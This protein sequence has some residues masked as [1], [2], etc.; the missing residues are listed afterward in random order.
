MRNDDTL[1]QEPGWLPGWSLFRDWGIL[2]EDDTLTRIKKRMLTRFTLYM[3]PLAL[4]HGGYLAIHQYYP[5]AIVIACYLCASAVNL[6][7][8][9]NQKN[10]GQF[11][12][13]QI[14]LI[15]LC[16]WLLTIL[17]GGF[18][19]SGG[20]AIW[21]ML[22]PMLTLLMHNDKA[23]ASWFWSVIAG[24]LSLIPLLGF[25]PHDTG[26][27][28][29]E[30]RVFFII[31]LCFVSTVT[32]L[33]I[34]YFT[35]R[36]LAL[37]KASDRLLFAIFPESVA[38]KLR[39]NGRTT[40]REHKDVTILFADLEG[41]TA[42]SRRVSAKE[43]VNWLDEMF[44]RIDEICEKHQLEKIKTIGDNYMAAAG[45][46]DYRED[47]AGRAFRMALE[48]RD[49]ASK[50]YTPDGE[51]IQFRI[52]LNSGPVIAGVIGQKK[53]I[54]DLWGE[55]VNLAARVEQAAGPGE[56]L[57][58][59]AVYKR[60]INPPEPLEIRMVNLRGVGEVPL[61]VY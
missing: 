51:K 53:F 1:A 21:M 18:A 31:N 34:R 32:Y 25:I 38:R 36:S 2:R 42:L 9:K 60:L 8:F 29:I 4:F 7:H 6:I 26:F 49:L 5:E 41:F 24:W 39:K 12:F 27:N 10:F 52:G 3:F 57:I 22:C 20:V 48:I 61:R 40:V 45:V 33:I 54:Y 56:V 58:T 37:Q 44:T 17:M 28:P 19:D 23:A 55:N 47:H 16:P 43:L 35:R 46:P 14:L 59:D 13:L 30:K 15:W 50:I 11:A